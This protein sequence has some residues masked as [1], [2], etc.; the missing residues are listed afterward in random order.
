MISRIMTP[1]IVT[2]SKP[3]KYDIE[4]LFLQSLRHHTVR[5]EAVYRQAHL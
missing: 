2:A 3:I 4:L 1:G 5:Y